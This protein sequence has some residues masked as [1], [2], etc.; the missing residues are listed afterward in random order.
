MACSCASPEKK[1][2]RE[3]QRAKQREQRLALRAARLQAAEKKV[4]KNA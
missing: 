3:A 4:V 1:A 2:A